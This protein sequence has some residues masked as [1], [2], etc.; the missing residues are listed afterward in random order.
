MNIYLI[1]FMGS[2]KSTIGKLLSKKLNMPFIDIDTTI[3]QTQGKIVSEIF[4]EMGEQKF[5]E[6][7]KEIITELAKNN[8]QVVALGGGAP[9]FFDNM[10]LLNRNGITIYLKMSPTA[11]YER[12]L[13]LP[14][15]AR[16]SRPLIANKTDKELFTF[17]ASTIEKREPFYNKAKL[18]ISNEGNDTSSTLERINKGLL[19]YSKNR[20]VE[21]KN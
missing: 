16:A 6:L 11:I 13:Q 4:S 18:I 15:K 19:F 9:C 17:I 10:E 8:N 3:E 5:R 14:P 2:G 7:E 12:L 20:T 1:G 21:E